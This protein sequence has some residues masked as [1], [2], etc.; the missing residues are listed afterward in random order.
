MMCMFV[1]RRRL[2]CVLVCWHMKSI[3]SVCCHLCCFLA[4]PKIYCPCFNN[5]S[6]RNEKKTKLINLSRRMKNSDRICS[7]EQKAR[8][9]GWLVSALSTTISFIHICVCR[10]Q[11]FGLLRFCAHFHHFTS[12]SINMCFA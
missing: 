10:C 8:G 9:V 12:Y 6:Y 4:A 11:W 2:F 5:N 1:F 7:G 3:C